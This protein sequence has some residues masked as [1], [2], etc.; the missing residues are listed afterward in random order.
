MKDLVAPRLSEGENAD[1]RVSESGVDHVNEAG[2]SSPFHSS[3]DVP[4]LDP[5]HMRPVVP[6]RVE[7]VLLR[8]SLA[9]VAETDSNVVVRSGDIGERVEL[10]MFKTT[11][12]EVVLDV[13]P[14]LFDELI[15]LRG[16][17]V[18]AR[19][20]RRGVLRRRRRGSSIR[21]R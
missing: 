13:L 10:E 12:L 4:H 21:D 3:P 16:R 11:D 1:R 15:A 18:G 6:D 7:A 9:P 8:A 5:F 19:G 14:Y 2:S 20:C 17:N